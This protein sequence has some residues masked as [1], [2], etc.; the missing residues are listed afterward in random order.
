MNKQPQLQ[1]DL[2][3]LMR[4]MDFVSRHPALQRDTAE[5][6]RMAEVYQQLGMAW[7]FL[8]LQCRHSGG[9]RKVRDGKSACKICGLIRGVKEQWL[10]LPRNGKKTIGRRALPNSKRTFPNR[11]AGTVVNDTIEF[12]GAKL[13]VEVLNPHR[14]NDRWFRKHDWTIAEDRLVRLEEGGVD[15][16][17]DSHLITVELCKHKRGE[18]PPY[19]HFVWELPRKFLKEFPVMLQFDKKRR[20]T[21]LVIFKPDRKTK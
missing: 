11:K 16:R 2:R 21:G 9:W 5:A 20:F 15:V 8:G 19:S 12:H 3:R 7:Q 13:N 6:R 17:F 18:M 4:C 1:R 10:L 14:C